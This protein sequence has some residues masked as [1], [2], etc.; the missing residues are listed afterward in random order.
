MSDLEL[1]AWLRREREAIRDKA[2]SVKWALWLSV[3]V[4]IVPLLPIL[5]E[6]PQATAGATH[7]SPIYD[8]RYLPLAILVRG[9]F[10]LWRVKRARRRRIV[11]ETVV[12]ELFHN[13]VVAPLAARCGIDDVAT[14]IDLRSESYLPSLSGEC[15]VVVPRKLVK[16]VVTRRQ[17]VEALVCHEL[18]H[19]KSGDHEMWFNTTI[20]I[21]VLNSLAIPNV[22]VTVTASL[23]LFSLRWSS[24]MSVPV[25]IELA[26]IPCLFKIRRDI[27]RLRAMSEACADKFAMRYVGLR[28]ISDAISTFVVEDEYGVGVHPSKQ[29]RLGRLDGSWSESRLQP[30]DQDVVSVGA[31]AVVALVTVG[32]TLFLFVFARFP[33]ALSS[34]FVHV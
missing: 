18:G 14:V 20:W 19:V 3:G 17:V 13:G 5:F 9:L 8:L 24:V 33:V 27:F 23:M 30:A 22:L 11:G 26:M 15:T 29:E 34:I 10:R 7:E 2:R 12:D 21:E 6:D 32:L 28:S 16:L 25:L 1:D 4:L 31:I